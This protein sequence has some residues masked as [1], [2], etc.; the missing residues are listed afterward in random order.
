MHDDQHFSD[1][2]KIAVACSPL[3][4]RKDE[5]KEKSAMEILQR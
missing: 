2:L 5:G 4:A 1:I 3:L